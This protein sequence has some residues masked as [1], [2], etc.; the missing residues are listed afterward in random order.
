MI[1]LGGVA[2][3]RSDDAAE[4]S[5]ATDGT[6][7]VRPEGFV[8]DIILNS[9]APVR[10]LRIVVLDPSSHD[11]VKL[12]PTEA[13]EVVQALSFERTDERLGECIR[14]GGAGWTLDASSP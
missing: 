10:S 2:I 9:G 1:R 4:L 3:V 6:V 13:D 14:L 8:E 7:I 12:I 5:F 11:I